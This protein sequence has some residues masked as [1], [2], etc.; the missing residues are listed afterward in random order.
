MTSAEVPGTKLA[1]FNSRLAILLAMAMFVLVVDTSIMNVSIAA[2]VE[3][4]G[5]TAAA[6]SR[7]SRSRLSCGGVHLDRRKGRRPRR[8]RACLRD[9]ACLL[10]AGAIAMVLAQSLVPD[11]HLLGHHRR[12]RRRAAP[13]GH[14]VAR[15]RQLRGSTRPTS[16]HWSGASSAIAVAI[17]PLLDD[18]ITTFIDW[19]VDFALEAVI[20]GDRADRH[21][22]LV[23][24]VKSP[25][26]NGRLDRFV[27]FRGRDRRHRARHP[28]LGRG[29]RGVGACC[30]GVAGLVGLVFWL[31]RSQ[32]AREGDL[33]RPGPLHVQAVPLRR[34]R[35]LPS[36][37]RSAAR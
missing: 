8:S 24:D 7:R 19:R 3:D 15:S 9:A 21:F 12:L 33:A 18:F 34:E 13:P 5:T 14:A 36:R 25:E 23:N 16:T 1:P 4:I 35:Q 22:Q 2:V 29:W 30:P 17:A 10:A 37:S 32:A 11:H 20:I 27:A 31:R 28:D 6:S 26:T